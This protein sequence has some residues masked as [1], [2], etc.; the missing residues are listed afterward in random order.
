VIV[1][2]AA[3]DAYAALMSLTP[4][5]RGL[6]L[7]WFCPDCSE[8]VASGCRNAAGC[9]GTGKHDRIAA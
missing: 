9:N 2:Q 7:C 3:R 8:H 6:V 1:P 4:R 5:E